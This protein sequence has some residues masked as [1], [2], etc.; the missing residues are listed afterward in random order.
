MERP[1]SALRTA[2]RPTDFAV[3]GENG[4][5]GFGLYRTVEAGTDTMPDI[6]LKR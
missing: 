1:L 3:C 5:S 2:R 6:E 4:Y